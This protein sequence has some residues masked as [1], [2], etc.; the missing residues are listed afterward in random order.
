MLGFMLLFLFCAK[1][2]DFF[3][4]DFT[5]SGEEK[6]GVRA[7]ASART[8]DLEGERA[9]SKEPFYASWPGGDQRKLY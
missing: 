6:R 9:T 3:N 7:C 4:R 8:G 2:C 1:M 5:L